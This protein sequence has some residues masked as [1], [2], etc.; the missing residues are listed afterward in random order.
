MTLTMNQI[1]GRILKRSAPVIFSPEAKVEISVGWSFELPRFFIEIEKIEPKCNFYEVIK[2]ETGLLDV[3]FMCPKETEEEVWR[4]IMRATSH[5][6]K[7]NR[8]IN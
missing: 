8:N 2:A 1:A 3:L 6:A 7:V 5:C 4:I